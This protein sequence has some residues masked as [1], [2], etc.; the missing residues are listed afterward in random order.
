MYGQTPDTERLLPHEQCGVFH[1]I[2]IDA[3]PM[4]D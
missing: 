4:Q 1:T 2:H 3:S